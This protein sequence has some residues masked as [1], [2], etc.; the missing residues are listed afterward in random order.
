MVSCW[1]KC[2]TSHHMRSH[3][4]QQALMP[5]PQLQAP[6]EVGN[7]FLE[8]S[9]SCVLVLTMHNLKPTTTIAGC[10]VIGGRVRWWAHHFECELGGVCGSETLAGMQVWSRSRG[11]HPSN[12]SKHFDEMLVPKPAVLLIHACTVRQWLSLCLQVLVSLCLL[13]VAT[14]GALVRLLGQI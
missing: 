13:L 14:Q 5:P 7:N 1:L 9:I 12:L 11:R 6:V 2:L 3:Q 8:A 4:A 10:G